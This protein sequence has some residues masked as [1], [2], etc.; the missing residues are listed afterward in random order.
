MRG[1][2]KPVPSKEDFI[3]DDLAGLIVAA[4]T[5]DSSVRFLIGEEHPHPL[6]IEIP[7]VI[8]ERGERVA[9]VFDPFSDDPPTGMDTLA[10]LAGQ[11]VTAGIA[12][13]DGSLDLSF[14]NGCSLHADGSPD[15][16][17]AWSLG[18]EGTILVSMP[19]GSLG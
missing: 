1:E 8:T 14:A 3:L 9:I 4:I 5:L 19:G 15:Q 11:P 13:A 18:I 17:E 6:R 16:Y 12:H 10:A 2:D 7:F